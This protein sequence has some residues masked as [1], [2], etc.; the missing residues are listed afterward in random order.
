MIHEFECQST[1]MFSYSMCLKIKCYCC[2]IFTIVTVYIYM[3]SYF[4]CPRPHF[5]CSQL[6]SSSETSPFHQTKQIFPQ[7]ESCSDFGRL[8]LHLEVSIILNVFPNFYPYLKNGSQLLIGKGYPFINNW[9]F[10]EM[11]LNLCI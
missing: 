1:F 10:I 8:S 9:P 4:V 11:A 5:Q 3:F 2:F 7:H 6:S